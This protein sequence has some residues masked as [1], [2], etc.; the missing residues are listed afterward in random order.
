MQ[1]LSISFDT[2]LANHEED[3]DAK[4]C[5]ELYPW[6]VFAALDYSQTAIGTP[7]DIQSSSGRFTAKVQH[8][9]IG[10]NGRTNFLIHLKSE[11]LSPSQRWRNRQWDEVF[12]V[13][14]T[15]DGDFITLF[16]KEQD[17]SK[18]LL[19]KFMAG[20][21]EQIEAE[22]SVPISGMLFRSL[23]SYVARDIFGSLKLSSTLGTCQARGRPTVGDQIQEAQP[24]LRSG[25][26]FWIMY[27]FTEE[28]AHR[29]AIANSA[30]CKKLLVVYCHPTFTKHHR[31]AAI[32]ANVISLSELLGMGSAAVRARYLPQLRFLM[33]HL[34]FDETISESSTELEL[35]TRILSGAEGRIEI[36]TSE[37]REAKAG[38]DRAIVTKGDAAYVLACANLLNAALNRKLRLYKG[39]QELEKDVYSFK[40]H[41]S[42][43]L[44]DLIRNTPDSTELYLSSEDLILVRINGIQLSF[45]AVPRTVA[46]RE[47]AL[48]SRNFPQ[49]WSGA[50]L[51]P[52][53]PLILSWARALV[54]EEGPVHT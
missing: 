39:T 51:Q 30:N 25:N 27:G 16:T 40:A 14:A 53:A 50:R 34:H 47:Y 46:L 33:N 6:E 8:C 43:C 10:N 22:R 1:M 41:L 35:R 28:K 32:N 54:R 20:G 29:I 45:H 5:R 24:F 17:P 9:F 2:W 31:C 4:W 19:R 36:K 38:L 12:Q 23:I 13:V 52:I 48:S 21:L 11:A 18:G 26:D 3:H 7:Q 15:P 44:E 42:R 37:L 49:A